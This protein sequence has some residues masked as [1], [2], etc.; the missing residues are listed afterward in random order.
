[1]RRGIICLGLQNGDEGKG[2]AT[3][4]LA[5]RVNPQLICRFSGG[6]QASHQ[7]TLSD[8]RSH[9]F[10]QWGSG[11]FLGIP[12]FIGSNVIINVRAMVNEAKHL[13]DV[14]IDKPWL[15][16]SVSSDCL[17]TTPYYQWL[18]QIKELA[19]GEHRHGSCGHGL[20]E[21]RSYWLKHG[22]DA[23][24][25]TDLCRIMDL[26]DKL[27]LLRQRLLPEVYEYGEHSQ[28]QELI[29]R[30][31]AVGPGEMAEDLIR[32]SQFLRI[33][34][35]YQQEWDTVVMEGAQGILLDESLGFHP[36]TTWST[37][38]DR[39]AREMLAEVGCDDITT[40]GCIRAFTTRHGAGPLPTYDPKLTA[41]LIDPGNPKNDWQGAL[42]VGWFDFPLY[43]Y[44]LGV[45]HVDALAVSWLDQFS[46]AGDKVAT[47]YEPIR[48]K[49]GPSL[50]EHSFRIDLKPSR[51]PNQIQQEGIGAVLTRAEPIYQTVAR[52][53]FLAMLDR[54]ILV[55]GFGPTFS[56]RVWDGE[57]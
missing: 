57:P 34:Y 37:T 56:D 30:F 4:F 23:I 12:T 15:L 11:S 16:L 51:Y 38:T 41:R 10:A 43:R 9:R 24:Y 2:S 8:G 13:V 20:G 45:Q 5:R 31:L 22:G 49:N 28:C 29:D 46:E 48:W 50:P 17:I 44:A 52:D 18:N 36:H 47:E 3:E 53:E 21:A 7:V 14:G 54:K 1:M 39:H 19:R 27:E 33:R 42:R 40:I 55:K 25:V 6:S 26:G 32:D 35:W